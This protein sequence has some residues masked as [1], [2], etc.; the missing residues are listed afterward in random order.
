MRALHRVCEKVVS[1]QKF[2]LVQKSFAFVKK[3]FFMIYTFS[4]P[5]TDPFHT[6][7]KSRTLSTFPFPILC[8]LEATH[9]N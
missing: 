2:I 1:K 3:N 6:H 5:F 9:E 4:E 8:F 7:P